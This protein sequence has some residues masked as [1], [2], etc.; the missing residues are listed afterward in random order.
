MPT[1]QQKQSSRN[2]N[3]V[4]LGGLLLVVAIVVSLEFLAPQLTTAR[5]QLE[6]DKAKLA[7]A[8]TDVQTLQAAKTQLTSSME[9]MQTAHSVNFDKVASTDPVTE[10]IPSLYLQLEALMNDSLT[11]GIS[12]PSYQVSVPVQDVTDGTVHIPLAIS[13][14]GTYTNLKAFIATLETNTRPISIQTLN[15]AQTLDKDKGAPS[16]QFTLSIAAVV[17]SQTLSAAYSTTTK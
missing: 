13:A 8:M 10:A 1:L 9:T 11:K 4:L 7:G 17:R 3:L 6:A 14:T 2:K 5:Q 16:N 15:L 12:N